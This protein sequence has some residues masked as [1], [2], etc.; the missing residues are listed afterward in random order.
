MV[1]AS[2]IHVFSIIGI[3]K[4]AIENHDSWHVLKG[5]HSI[6]SSQHPKMQD[7]PPST[8]LLGTRL[9]RPVEIFQCIWRATYPLHW[10]RMVVPVEGDSDILHC[11]ESSVFLSKKIV[12]FFYR[13]NWIKNFKKNP[14][15][16]LTFIWENI[17]KFLISPN[18]NLKKKTLQESSK[19]RTHNLTKAMI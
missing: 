14:S 2:S 1:R 5:F 13:K 4:M 7:C 17:A 19:T 11:Q 15:V 18:L 10:E 16:N 6:W 8:N 9:Q 12:L 3:T